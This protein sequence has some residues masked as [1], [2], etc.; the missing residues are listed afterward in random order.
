MREKWDHLFAHFTCDRRPLN[1]TP[2]K[3]GIKPEHR[4][5]NIRID[6]YPLNRTKRVQMIGYTIECDKNGFWLPI[7]NSLINNPYTMI[8]KAPDLDGYKRGR[9][10]FDFRKLNSLCELKPS[11]HGDLQGK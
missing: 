5:K 11:Y 3:L 6:Q 8:I 1:I 9:P 4:D 2:V 7:K 10:V